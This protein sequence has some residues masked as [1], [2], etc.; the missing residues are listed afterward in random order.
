MTNKFEMG[1]YN[2]VAG[3]L[4]ELRRTHP[5]ASLQPLNLDK[6]FDIVTLAETT[7]IVY[8][9]ACYR[10]PDDIRR[11]VGIAWEQFPGRTPY[12]KNSEI[13][14]AETS[15]WGRA[16]VAALAADTR[17]VASDDEVAFGRRDPTPDAPPIP[18]GFADHAEARAERDRLKA[19]VLERGV[20]VAEWVSA[21]HSSGRGTVR[22]AKRFRRSSTRANCSSNQC[23]R[24]HS[25]P[26]GG[27]RARRAHPNVRNDPPSKSPPDVESCRVGWSGRRSREFRAE[28]RETA[29]SI[30][31]GN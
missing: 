19:E 14:N 30:F 4:R 5:D 25:A 1:D 10:T 2:D 6:P 24:S 8:A 11:G 18:D 3:R 12:T 28:V 20:D 7:W 17:R 9:A 26:P 29:D 15:A 16:I 27:H 22:P 31:S 13:M 21:Q 23:D